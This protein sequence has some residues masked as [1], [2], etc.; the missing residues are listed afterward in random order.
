MGIFKKISL[1]LVLDINIFK[2]KR[3]LKETN[4]VLRYNERERISF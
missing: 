3:S 4:L 1:N 2:Q